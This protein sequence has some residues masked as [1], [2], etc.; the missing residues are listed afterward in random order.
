ML[1][2]KRKT[3]TIPRELAKSNRDH[4]IHLGTLELGLFK[5]QVAVRPAGSDLIFPTAEGKRWTQPRFRDRV[6]YPALRAT[7]ANDPNTGTGARSVYDGFQFAYLRKTA[8]S[9]MGH[10]GIDPKVA[11]ER[12]E[13]KDG[14][15]LYLR[16]YRHLYDD[17]RILHSAR[18]DAFVQSELDKKG[19][20][21]P[22]DGRDRLGQ[23]DPSDGRYWARTSDPQLVELV[24]SQLS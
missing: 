1:D 6:W 2:L 21:D 11:S 14:G 3:V 17:E 10:A 23:G 22:A 13:H 5:E 15:A 4:M 8:A 9:L 18:Y 16:T 12:M 7:I 20:K 19:T 24:L